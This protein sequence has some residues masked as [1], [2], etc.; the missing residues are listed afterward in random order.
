MILYFLVNVNSF[1]NL[2]RSF[3]RTSP[4]TYYY[5]LSSR[6]ILRKILAHIVISAV[7]FPTT[8]SRS[9]NRPSLCH[10]IDSPLDP[11]ECNK[12]PPLHPTTPSVSTPCRYKL[13]QHILFS[14]LL[15]SCIHKKIEIYYLYKCLSSFKNNSLS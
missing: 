1:H 12:P 11:L 8:P 6:N 5:S 15:G 4:Y 3:S 10:P 2:L 14:P 7:I 13:A 9:L